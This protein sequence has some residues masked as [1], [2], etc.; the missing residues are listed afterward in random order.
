MQAYFTYLLNNC[1]RYVTT[2][3]QFKL[4]VKHEN[5]AHG[6]QYAFTSHQ[7][8]V[9]LWLSNTT[10]LLLASTLLLSHV[11]LSSLLLLLALLDTLGLL[12]AAQSGF[13]ATAQA[14]EVGIAVALINVRSDACANEVT[15]EYKRV[16][17][18]R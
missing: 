14:G 3:K 16:R 17:I 2:G 15:E 10:H 4:Q 18:I 1:L 7:R 6:K 12:S 9:K 5:T 13:F 8:Q 11:A